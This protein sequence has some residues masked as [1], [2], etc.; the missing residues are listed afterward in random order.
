MT[1]ESH[2]AFAYAIHEAA[3]AVVGHLCGFQVKRMHIIPERARGQCE[4]DRGFDPDEACLFVRHSPREPRTT[5]LLPRLKRDLAG[6]LAGMIGDS[7]H[8]I[9]GSE[10][11]YKRDRKCADKLARDILHA[12]Y[13]RSEPR[14]AF[15]ER[16]RIPA[17]QQRMGSFVRDHL[18]LP[19]EPVVIALAEELESKRELTA[20]QITRVFERFALP[21]NQVSD[22]SLP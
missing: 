16:E 2:S 6:R 5:D 7:M 3:H 12:T 14:P 10:A 18:L 4:I 21:F 17:Y 22:D 8:G 15:S 19:Y 1:V 9:Q 13:F 11:E 20:E